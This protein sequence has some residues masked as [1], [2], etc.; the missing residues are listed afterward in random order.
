MKKTT[1]LIT[2]AAMLLGAA[3]AAFAEG[4]DYE[5]LLPDIKNRLE[6]PTEYSEFK[7]NWIS[8]TEDGTSYGFE[9]SVPDTEDELYRSIN[10][11]CDSDG[12]ITSYSNRQ[13]KNDDRYDYLSADTEA[14]RTAAE[15]FAVR[16]DPSL[17]GKLRLET[18]NGYN[19]GALS[20]NVY[21]ERNGIE[22]DDAIGS[23]SVTSEG[24]V[25]DADITSP[26]FSDEDIS[27]L[28]TPDEAYSS[29]M[30][31]AEPELVY[32]TYT[33]KENNIKTFPAYIN[34]EQKAVSAV[35]GD[36]I[37]R[38]SGY[39]NY[40]SEAAMDAGASVMSGRVYNELTESEKQETAKLRGYFSGTDALK[41]LSDLIGIEINDTDIYL[42]VS[43]TSGV[44]Y[45]Y[46]DKADVNLNAAVDAANG[47]ILSLSYYDKDGSTKLKGYD[48]SD[49]ESAKA[50]IDAAAP[51]NGPKLVY[52]ADGG[53]EYSVM[54]V[55]KDSNEDVEKASYF[56]F[57]V[58]GIK[59]M[60]AGASA[61][62]S[63]YNGGT[64]YSISV[65]RL[66]ELA[67][68]EYG[69]PEKFIKADEALK[70]EDFR[71]R[72][73]MTEDDAR[74]AYTTDDFIIN[75][76]TGKRVNFRDEEVKDKEGNYTYSD[77]GNHWV[78]QAAEK[79][80]LAGI[81]FEGGVLDPDKPVTAE[82]AYKLL[83]KQYYS[84]DKTFKDYKEPLTR[85]QTAQMI[86]E[87]LGLSQLAGADIFKAPYADTAED[88]GAVAILK[89]YGIIAGDTD[90]FRPD[91]KITRAEFLQ[92]LY[93]TLICKR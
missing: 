46:S 17:E 75:A 81:G 87:C 24:T 49:P 71:L 89:G 82:E 47:N 7:C 1:A 70:P 26:D 14:A 63:A 13:G 66:D 19:W 22:Y 9:W 16:M 5:K 61:V 18:R 11:T 58:N 76:L 80:A 45:I 6:I 40:K 31:N 39:A 54:P 57:M 41:K 44:Y 34:K 50:L 33:D 38:S 52:D 90:S 27:D 74:A 79:L 92:I 20:F 77:I 51:D 93:S 30:K 2:A 35:T 53:T 4:A 78:K 55:Y 8:E 84:Y 36:V 29:Y 85:K 64:Y 62:S 28:I 25:T 56:S 32:Y 60:D 37:E 48:F 23:V 21:E 65:T 91:D 3:P 67:A 73:V 68:A 12:V 86:T 69:A 43:D 83:D 88:F 42:N 72:Y 59:V 15:R 10:V